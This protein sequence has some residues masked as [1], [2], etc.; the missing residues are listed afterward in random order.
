MP[1]NST[2]SQEAPDLTEDDPR[3]S[4][5]V[6]RPTRA[7][8]EAAVELLL[9][10]AGDDP[11]RS[12]VD[13]S[14]TYFN[15]MSEQQRQRVREVAQRRHFR[16]SI[17]VCRPIP[18]DKNPGWLCPCKF[19]IRNLRVER[20]PAD[21]RVCQSIIDGEPLLAAVVGSHHAL[22]R[23]CQDNAFAGNHTCDFL[24]LKRAFNHAPCAIFPVTGCQSG[25]CGKVNC[26]KFVSC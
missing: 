1:A 16:A 14:K 7:E 12:G 17:P 4:P 23:S 22:C 9:R 15:L 26:H 10:W 6:A 18:R 3:E 20:Q 8:A 19:Q 24:I 13:N 25:I 21:M 11:A 2:T 5:S